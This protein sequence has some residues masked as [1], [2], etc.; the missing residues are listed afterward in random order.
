M[1]AYRFYFLTADDHIKSAETIDCADHGAAIAMAGALLHE[2]YGCASIEVW[3]G[4]E[5]VHHARREA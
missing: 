1:A 2:R 4:K 3:S 5:L